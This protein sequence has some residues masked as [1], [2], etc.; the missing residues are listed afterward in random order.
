MKLSFHLAYIA[1]MIHSWWPL[2][3]GQIFVNSFERK[4]GDTLKTVIGLGSCNQG[5]HPFFYPSVTQTLNNIYLKKLPVQKGCLLKFVDEVLKK[6]RK[7]Q[8]ILILMSAS[9]N[10]DDN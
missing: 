10:I 3:W 5:V 2:V 7:P 4:L 6:R 9:D 1:F 8:V